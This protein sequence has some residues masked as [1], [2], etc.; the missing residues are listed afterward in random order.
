MKAEPTLF[1]WGFDCSASCDPDERNPLIFDTPVRVSDFAK[2]LRLTDV[3]T[4][5]GTD[6]PKPDLLDDADD[7]MGKGQRRAADDRGRAL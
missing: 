4:G 5:A 7:E 6:L 3:T 1:V 2:S